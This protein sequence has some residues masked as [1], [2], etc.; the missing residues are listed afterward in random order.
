MKNKEIIM[1]AAMSETRV[2]GNEAGDA[3]PWSVPEE[4]QRYVDTV[5]GHTVI[6]GYSSFMINGK[7]LEGVELIVL[8]RSHEISGVKVCTSLNQ[9]IAE[10]KH[11]KIFIAGGGQVYKHA[12]DHADQI[13]LSTIKGAYSGSVYF[14]ELDKAKWI[15]DKEEELANYIF[16]VYRRVRLKS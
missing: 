13:L 12:L 1:I 4:Y 7:Y 2:I 9:A 5:S 8:S 3:M 6:M 14:P 16:R 10:A 11:S 15:L